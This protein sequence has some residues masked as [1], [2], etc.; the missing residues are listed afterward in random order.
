M[1]QTH[2]VNCFDQK[3]ERSKTLLN[4]LASDIKHWETKELYTLND[5]CIYFKPELKELAIKVQHRIGKELARRRI[6]ESKPVKP[7]IIK[8]KARRKRNDKR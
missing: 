4:W 7:V 5:T 6:A 2:L 1:L 3:L 8:H